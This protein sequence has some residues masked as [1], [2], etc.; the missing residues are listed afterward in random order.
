MD[1]KTDI[2][3]RLQRRKPVED[4]VSGVI[5]NPKSLRRSIGLES[6]GGPDLVRPFM[7]AECGKTARSV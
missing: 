2:K 3:K 1:A 5:R 7:K 6:N 4:R